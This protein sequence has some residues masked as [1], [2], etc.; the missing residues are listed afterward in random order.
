MALLRSGFTIAFFTLFSKISGLYRELFI[1]YLF[2]AGSLADNINVAFKLP[3]LFRR[4]FSEGALSH[5]FIPIFNAKIMDSKELAEKFA[6]SIISIL[7]ITLIVLVTVI[8]FFMPYVIFILAPGFNI[9]PG[10]FETTISLCRITIFYVIFVSVVALIGGILNSLNRFAEFAFSPILLNL[11][12][13]FG[14]AA[15]QI[16]TTLERAICYSLLVG[17]VVQVLVMYICLK[18]S[19]IRLCFRVDFFDSSVKNFF[20]NIGPSIL[21]SSI[22]QVNIFISQAVS[23]F[24][25]GAISILSY[26]DRIYQFPLAIIGIGFS[27]ILLPELSKLYKQKLT[28]EII[29]MQNNSI[30]TGVFFSF[31]AAVGLGILSYPIAELVY[32]HGVFTIEDTYKTAET[33]TAYTI[34]LPAF[35]INKILI[36]LFYAS[37]DTK[38]P[39]KV[40][41][42]SLFINT[43]LNILLMF[44]FKHVGIALGTSIASWYSVLLLIIY[45]KKIGYCKFDETLVTFII[46]SFISCLLMAVIVYYL[47]VIIS[48]F[49]SGLIEKIACLLFCIV[50]GILVYF[51]SCY[52]LG[53]FSIEMLKLKKMVVK[54]KTNYQDILKALAI[55]TMII[56]HI[57]WYFFPKIME[58]RIIGRYAMPVFCFFSGYNFKGNPNNLIVKLGGIL[59]AQQ[60]IDPFYSGFCVRANILITIYLGQVYLSISRKLN[61][62]IQILLLVL[63]ISLFPYTKRIFEYGTLGIICMVIGNLSINCSTDTRNRN[64]VLMN[65][66]S[67]LHSCYTLNLTDLG[68]LYLTIV[69]IVLHTSLILFNYSKLVGVDFCFI[70]RNSLIIYFGHIFVLQ[71]IRLIYI[72]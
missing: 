54:N 23:S 7:I 69:Y 50:V 55:I 37:C 48:D 61:N 29:V 57:G 67:F 35:I 53:I 10:K 52:L 27:T 1:A 32:Y 8:Q 26:A 42:Y 20:H 63:L 22:L 60:I 24:I 9:I 58:L 33:I 36:S 51:L 59:Y 31:P 62:Y 16:F 30:K 40:T 13:I 46:K 12:V 34:G 15:I 66:L 68:F 45:A 14:T 19:N 11:M 65:M 43:L 49:N 38:T 72:R 41:I 21:S 47:S 6:S 4:T 28:N 2:G 70:S 17:G 5:V 18:Q 56:D 44:K 71:F 39:M 64:I 3:N 25:P